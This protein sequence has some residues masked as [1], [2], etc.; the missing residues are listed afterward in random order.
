MPAYIYDRT[1]DGYELCPTC[2][3]CA[4][5]VTLGCPDDQTPID[6]GRAADPGELED[7]LYEE[8]RDRE[9]MKGATDAE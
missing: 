9:M 5:L 8:K 3:D 6:C 7:R 1:C 2:A 4:T